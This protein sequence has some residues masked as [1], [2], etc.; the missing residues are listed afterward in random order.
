MAPKASKTAKSGHYT[1]PTKGILSKLPASWVPYAE[2]VRLEQPHGIYMIYFPHIVGL[3]YACSARPS[4]VP[5]SMLA[6]RLV[7]FAIWTFFMRGAG[8]AWNDITDQDFDRKTER[9]RNRP[10]ARGA[11]STTQGHVFTL[12]LTALGFL[13]LQSLPLEC[14]MCALVTTVLTTIYPFGK[15][16]TNFA[17]V[18]LGSTLASTIT[19]SAYSV[20]LPALSPGY[21]IPTLCLTATILLLVVFYDT[22][23]A[24]QDTADDLKSGVKGM[25]VLF[26]NHIETLLAVLALSIAG[27]LATT[28]TLLN[29]G[30]YFFAFSVVGLATGLLIMIALIRWHL[31]PSFAK[32]SGWFYALA[33][34]NLLGGCVVEY[35]N[36]APT[37]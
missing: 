8:C 24:R 9:C 35:L 12:A 13:T 33:I 17:Q 34:V 25:A 16:F 6:H 4:A 22:I 28:G 7:V 36:K 10:V 11:I 21:I 1:P 30:P 26:R 18:I 32:Y 23:Y 29:M 20:E 14:T 37:L 5:A 19:L 2:L 15:R 31:F 27:L 3:M